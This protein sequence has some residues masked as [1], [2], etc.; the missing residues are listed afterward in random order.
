MALLGFSMYKISPFFVPFFRLNQPG[1]KYDVQP[2]RDIKK[3][4]LQFTNS[5]RCIKA[6]EPL[7]TPF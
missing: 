3:Q 5:K 4:I 6:K 2:V 1:S 7:K